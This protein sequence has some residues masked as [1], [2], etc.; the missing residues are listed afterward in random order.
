M[1]LRDVQSFVFN[2]LVASFVIK[3]NLLQC[4]GDFAFANLRRPVYR[5]PKQPAETAPFD[6]SYRL[7]DL[8]RIVKKNMQGDKKAVAMSRG[9][10]FRRSGGRVTFGALKSAYRAAVLADA[11][12]W[13]ALTQPYGPSPQESSKEKLLRSNGPEGG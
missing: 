6:H 13:C 4:A 8:R 7:P 10:S 11:V 3:N 12:L 1:Q 2:I 9:S 5:S